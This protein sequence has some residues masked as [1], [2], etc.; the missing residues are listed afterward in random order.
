MMNRQIGRLILLTFLLFLPS[1]AQANTVVSDRYGTSWTFTSEV[2]D[3]DGA[4]AYDIHY[5][6]SLGSGWI[7]TDELPDVEVHGEIDPL[8]GQP[9]VIWS[10]QGRDGQFR[11]WESFF[12]GA[13]WSTPRELPVYAEMANDRN[14]YFRFGPSGVSIYITFLR[15]SSGQQRLMFGR[16]KYAAGLWT[17]C[18]PVV[19]APAAVQF[20]DPFLHLFIQNSIVDR[21]T[22]G[23]IA[24]YL[25]GH[26]D[27]PPGWSGPFS[28]V[29][30]LERLFSS[31]DTS[32]WFYIIH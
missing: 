7:T 13:S 27:Q 32:P 23:Y 2:Q 18:S 8:S 30:M 20:Q 14:C 16:Y 10:R 15:E 22:L 19:T 4:P 28:T 9:R 1:V 24:V 25:S 6:S 31:G 5:A 26:P 11:L 21:V 12:N 17:E 3:I 29:E